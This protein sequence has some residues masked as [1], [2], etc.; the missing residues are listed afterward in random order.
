MFINAD[1]GERRYTHFIL[2]EP[3]QPQAGDGTRPDGNAMVCIEVAIRRPPVSMFTLEVA[4]VAKTCEN[5]LK[6]IA[7]IDHDIVQFEGGDSVEQYGGDEM[8]SCAVNYLEGGSVPIE[9]YKAQRIE[10]G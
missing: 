3:L 6:N 4:Q 2:V 7:G 9:A 1:I 8:E 5:P 10:R